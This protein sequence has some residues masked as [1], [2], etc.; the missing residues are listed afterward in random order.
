MLNVWGFEAAYLD[1]Y[2][3][4]FPEGQFGWMVMFA[5]GEEGGTGMPMP[6]FLIYTNKENAISG[7]YNTTRGN[8]DLES[9]Y[10]NTNGTLH[11]G[12]RCRGAHTVRCL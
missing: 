3:D 8:I 7:V 11:H 1:T 2:V 9:C 4:Q 12:Y 10:I 5:T 6:Y